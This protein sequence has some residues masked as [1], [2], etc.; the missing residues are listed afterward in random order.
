MMPMT[1]PID[2]IQ[3]QTI[4]VI[5]TTEVPLSASAPLV[6]TAAAEIGLM[7]GC[8]K[9]LYVRLYFRNKN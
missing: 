9:M 8:H 3:E 6:A 1:N 7:A 5:A 4:P 2:M